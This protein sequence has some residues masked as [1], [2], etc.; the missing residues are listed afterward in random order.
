LR[1]AALKGA[2]RREFQGLTPGDRPGLPL[3]VSSKTRRSAMKNE[4]EPRCEWKIM[5]RWGRWLALGCALPAIWAC[6]TRSLGEAEHNPDQSIT[7]KISSAQ[8]S[9]LDILFMIDNSASM[10]PLQAKLLAQFPQFMDK[11]KAIPTADGMGM[12][13]PD[14]HVA[15]ISSDTGPGQFDL[16]TYGCLYGGDRGAFQFAPRGNCTAPPLHTTPAQQTFLS[17]SMNQAVKNYDGDIS[18]AFKCIAALG[19]TGCGF[20]GQLKSVRLALDGSNPVND[21][22]LRPEAFLAV[23]LITNEDD[24][25]LPNDSTLVDPAQNLMTDPLGPLDSF[26]C[27]EFGHLCNINGTLQPPPRGAATN[28]Q[29]CVSNDT[30]TGK[31][32]KVGDEVAFLRSLKEDPTQIFVAAITG[33]PTP[34]SIE[35]LPESTVNPMLVPTMSHSC[36]ETTGEY[37]DPAVRI[38]QWVDAFGDHGLRDTICAD[39]FAPALQSIADALIVVLGNQCIAGSL[40]DTDPSTATPDPQCQVSDSYL[41]DQKHVIETAIHACATNATPPCWSLV[42]DAQCPGAKV[43]QVTRG[44]GSLPDGLQTSISCAKCVDGVARAGCPCVAGKEVAGCL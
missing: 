30:A 27:N 7:R 44:P 20:E 10:K 24:C 14:I 6:N 33:P 37:A 41:D 4:G 18:D 15:V 11:L 35:M 28:L 29:D 32:T 3:A 26:R 25:S 16:P 34:Y 19:D 2:E 13:L 1:A 5:W 23:I 17:A 31:L 21:G 40:V 22:F 43:L 12:S 39:S 36:T 9:K 42:D 8:V 38:A